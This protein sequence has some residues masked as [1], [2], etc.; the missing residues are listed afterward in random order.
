MFLNLGSNVKNKM[1]CHFSLSN[2][3]IKIW[4]THKLIIFGI[5][6][7]SKVPSTLGQIHLYLDL[8]SYYKQHS[9]SSERPWHVD[10]KKITMHLWGADVFNFE[11]TKPIINRWQH[12]DHNFTNGLGS[13]RRH[14]TLQ[15]HILSRITLGN[16]CL[17]C[18]CI[19]Q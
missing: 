11:S 12:F 18:Q 16:G 10:D 14:T 3:F 9:R 5:S 13:Q 1:L 15:S 4:K 17:E 7:A 19:Q 8:V 6:C 2:P